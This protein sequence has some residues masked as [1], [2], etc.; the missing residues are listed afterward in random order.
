LAYLPL[1]LGDELVEQG[2][3]EAPYAPQLGGPRD[4][5]ARRHVTNC[6]RLLGEPGDGACHFAALSFGRHRINLLRC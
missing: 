4:L 2:N 3:V 5:A 6:T 1:F